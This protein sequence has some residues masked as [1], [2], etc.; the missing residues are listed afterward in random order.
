[1]ATEKAGVKWDA[2]RGSWKAVGRKGSALVV[3][4]WFPVKGNATA[5]YQAYRRSV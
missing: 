4:G 3:I 1:M 2:V 5:A